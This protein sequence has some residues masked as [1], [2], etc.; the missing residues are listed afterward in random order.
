MPR[1]VPSGPTLIYRQTPGPDVTGED[2]APRAEDVRGA[3][4]LA[5]GGGLGVA[6]G[7][8]ALLVP[9][10]ALWVALYHPTG[11]DRLGDPLVD[12]LSGL[13]LA[14]AILLLLCLLF[15]RSAYSR[16]RRV[17]P[18]FSVASFLCLIGSVGFLLVVVAA[19]V[20][21]GSAG[22]LVVCLHGA[23]AHALGCLE[24]GT[25]LGGYTALVGFWLGWL[26]G[27]GIVVGLAAA[28][29]RFGRG[30]LYAGAF[31]YAAL[32]LVLIG[33]F[34]ALVYAVPDMADLLLVLPFLA[35]VAPALVLLGSAR[36]PGTVRRGAASR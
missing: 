1:P 4:R 31:L 19:T 2:V 30:S 14:G 17:D 32:L 5:I 36:P 34:L 25:P 12:L 7:V 26:G 22:S 3:H 10:L 16:L 29:R 11:F 15:Y 9:T 20:F 33:P 27:A 13:V 6:A 28:G 35:V 8:V 18:R 24:S 21:L 23:P